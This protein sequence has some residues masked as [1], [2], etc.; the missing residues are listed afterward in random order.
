MSLIFVL[1]T[2]AVAILLVWL[3]RFILITNKNTVPINIANV[4][5]CTNTTI[6]PAI[7][8]KVKNINSNHN[9][10]FR[11]D[12]SSTC[13]EYLYNQKIDVGCKNENTILTCLGGKL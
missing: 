6:P 4:N 7:L 10:P 2:F 8:Y 1:I 9:A 11:S 13:L 3:I 5:N 12:V